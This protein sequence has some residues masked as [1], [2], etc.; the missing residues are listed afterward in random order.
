MRRRFKAPD[1]AIRIEVPE[2]LRLVSDPTCLETVLRNVLDNAV[3]YSDEP[4]EVVLRAK[5]LEGER[6]SIEVRDQGIGIPP[7]QLRRVFQRF[8][9]VD[10]ESVRRRRG[11]GL[12]LFVVS[13]LVHTLGGEL[14]AESD[15]L[16]LGTTMRI[17][18]PLAGKEGVSLGRPRKGRSA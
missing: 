3:K 11:T 14:G 1:E 7:D 8:Y 12:G 6:V 10:T 17:T 9:R 16:G 18:L 4:V 13:S 5:V 2:G 15:G